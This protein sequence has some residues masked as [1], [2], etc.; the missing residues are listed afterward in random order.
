M[1]VYYGNTRSM[2]PEELQKYDMVI[3]TYQTVAGEHSDASKGGLSK[4]KKKTEQTLFNIQW[5]VGL[6]YWTGDC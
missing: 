2:S 4:K 1:C 3:T 6:T 5:K